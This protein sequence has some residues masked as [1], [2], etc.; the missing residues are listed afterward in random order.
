MGRVAKL[1]EAIL[2]EVSNVVFSGVGTS[3]LSCF[4]GELSAADTALVATGYLLGTKI[5][6]VKYYYCQ[7][8]WYY[9]L[10]SSSAFRMLPTYSR[11]PREV[12]LF[13]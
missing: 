13:S 6:S 10:I 7:S 9:L 8:M 3:V 5:V 11:L 12:L 4:P 1:K 2:T